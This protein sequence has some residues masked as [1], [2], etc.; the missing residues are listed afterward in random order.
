MEGIDKL[1]KE[2]DEAKAQLEKQK[3]EVESQELATEQEQA[4]QQLTRDADVQ[5]EFLKLDATAKK[6]VM[7]LVKLG[8][9]LKTALAQYAKASKPDFIKLNEPAR[10]EMELF[11][12]RALGFNAKYVDDQLQYVGKEPTFDENQTALLDRYKTLYMQAYSEALAG[13]IT[14]IRSSNEPAALSF[15]KR[16]ADR[17]IKKLA[18]GLKPKDPTGGPKVPTDVGP[19]SNV[20]DLKTLKPG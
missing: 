1:G 14:G 17:E 13:G 18:G 6:E 11:A 5:I 15:A 7:S 4:I 20:T 3:F 12:L 19:P 8:V 16:Y 10:K 9:D 2:L